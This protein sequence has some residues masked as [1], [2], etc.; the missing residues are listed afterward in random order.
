MQRSG[1]GRI[2]VGWL[3]CLMPPLAPDVAQEN[4]RTGSRGEISNLSEGSEILVADC[5]FGNL[6]VNPIGS[7]GTGKGL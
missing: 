1:K 3:L 5:S 6:R 7:L 4:T 2:V